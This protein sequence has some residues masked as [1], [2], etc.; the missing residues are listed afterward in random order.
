MVAL[1]RKDQAVQAFVRV[2]E[3]QPD[4]E[5]DGVSTSPKVLAAFDEAQQATQP[6]RRPRSKKETARRKKQKKK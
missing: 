4:A 1:D 2:L 6:K 3:Q 5:L